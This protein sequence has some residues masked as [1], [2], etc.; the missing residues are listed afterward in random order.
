MSSNLSDPAFWSR[1]QF[2][3]TITYHWEATSTIAFGSPFGISF[4]S[5]QTSS[6]LVCSV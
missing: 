4:L 2:G 3:F 6:L 1:L 5:C